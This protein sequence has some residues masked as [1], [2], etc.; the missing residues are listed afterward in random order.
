MKS[1]ESLKRVSLSPPTELAASDFSCQGFEVGSWR[2]DGAGLGVCET[3]S[4]G[5]M[6]TSKSLLN[7]LG[8]LK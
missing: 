3:R 7:W 5:F 6:L 2:E 4:L 8:D 1:W